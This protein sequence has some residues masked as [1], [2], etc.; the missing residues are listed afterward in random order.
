MPYGV[1]AG[2]DAGLAFEVLPPPV[3]TSATPSAGG[4]LTAGTYKYYITAI[5]AAGETTVSNELTG[6][7]SAGNLTL[8]LLWAAVTGATGYKIY[9]TA[10]AGATGTEL[11]LTSVGAVTTYNDAAVGS[12]AGAFPTSNTASAPGIY[13]APTKFFP[14]NTESIKFVQ[15]TVWRRPIRQTADITGASPGNAHVEGD[16]EMEVYEDVLPYFLYAARTSVV[17]AGSGNYTYTFTPTSSAVPVRTL[18]ITIE[19]VA[20][21]VFGYVGCVVSSLKFGINNGMLIVTIG[22]VGRDEASQATPTPVWPTSGAFGAGMYSVEFPTGSPVLDTDT[23]EFTIDD[24]ATPDFRMK[25]TGRGAALIHFG[26]RNCSLHAERDF[27]S[28]SDYDSLFKAYVSQSTTITATKGTNNSV[29]ILSQ[30]SIVDTYEVNLSGQGDL[31]R[32]AINYQVTPN[33]GATAAYQITV[34]TQENI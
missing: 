23:F 16:I 26:E 32:A 18:S 12:P 4:A 7:T 14:F 34:K 28:R 17:K 10:A 6:T 22:I 5:N 27:T 29:S 8:T 9:R 19:R 30:Q 21:V 25:S 2:G 13:V 11:L 33:L 15:D 24:Q 31:V 3:A 20:G 1:G